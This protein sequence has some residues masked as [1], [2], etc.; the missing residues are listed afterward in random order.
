VDF[1]FELVLPD[2][3]QTVSGADLIKYELESVVYHVGSMNE[4]HYV[5]ISKRLND[6]YFFNDAHPPEK[7]DKLSEIVNRAAYILFYRKV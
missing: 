6:W 3:E 5:A 4:G 1:G 7:V 2:L